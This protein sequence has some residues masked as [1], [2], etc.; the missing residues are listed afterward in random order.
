MPARLPG[1]PKPFRV[2]TGPAW[3]EVLMTVVG[4]VV[5]GKSLTPNL[6]A[7]ARSGIPR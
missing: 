4:R 2:Q 6:D 7:L 5:A 3:R 1:T